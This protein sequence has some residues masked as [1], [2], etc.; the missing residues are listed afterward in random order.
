MWGH[1]SPYL[2]IQWPDHVF[3]I[4]D[5]AT[6]ALWTD[7]I[8]T[9]FNETEASS[10][11]VFDPPSSP[12][13]DGSK[14]G[15]DT[16]TSLQRSWTTVDHLN[17][18]N[19]GFSNLWRTGYASNNTH[20]SPRT[21][22]GLQLDVQPADTSD[23][24]TW[25]SALLTRRRDIQ[26][27]SLRTSM[28]APR[29]YEGGTVLQLGI[30]Y[31]SSEYI[32]SALYSASQDPRL[33]T[34]QWSYSAR[35]A[36][37]DPY[38]QNLTAALGDAPWSSFT[39]HRI[40]WLGSDRLIFSNG[41]LPSDGAVNQ[42]GFDKETDK[43]NLPTLG[44]PVSLSHFSSGDVSMQQ[45]PPVLHQPEARVLY[46]RL[47]FNS[48]SL[49][50]AEAFE[51][52]CAASSGASICSTEDE[53]LRESTPF[54]EEA[55]SPFSARS[56]PR[57]APLYSVIACS[58]AGGLFVLLLVH[59]LSVRY[60]KAN[61]TKKALQEMDASEDKSQEVVA[62]VPFEP[63]ARPSTN[64]SRWEDPD[65]VARAIRHCDDDIDEEDEEAETIVDHMEQDDP[66][67]INKTASG[68][69]DLLGH[70]S[71]ND[72]DKLGYV[73]PQY[74]LAYEAHA[75]RGSDAHSL[76]PSSS[77]MSF[78]LSKSPA[79]GSSA[80]FV[81]SERTPSEGGHWQTSS[82]DHHH[83]RW[84]TPIVEWQAA[85]STDQIPAAGPMAQR[86]DRAQQIDDPTHAAPHRASHLKRFSALAKTTLLGSGSA[87][88]TA[89]G[90]ARVEYL[91]GLR[92]FACFL[93]SLHH[94]LLIFYY[95]ITTVN[96]PMHYAGMETWLRKI[97]GA[98]LV[99][100]GLNVGI[101]FFLAARV[102]A[103]RYLVRGRLQD[104][105]EAIHRRVPRLMLPISAAI[106]INYFLIEAD[107]FHWVLRLA[108][109]TWSPWSY[110]QNYENLGVFINDYLALWFT[111][112]PNVPPLVSLYATGILWTVPVIVQSSWTVFLCALVAREIP[113]PK[114]RYTFYGAC[115]VLS[116][117]ANRFDYFFIAGLIMA[118][119]DNRVKYRQK[120][121]HGFP[122]APASIRERLAPRIANIRVHGQ[123]AAWVVFLTGAVFSWLEF[124]GGSGSDVIKQ[125]HGIHPDWPSSK[126]NA[127][128][129]ST[130]SVDYTDPRFFDF[131]FV[132]GFFLLC[133]L[134][135]SFRTFFQLRFWSAFGRNAFSLYLLHGV[136][137]WS[138]GAW[139]CLALLKH[140]VPY[141]AAVLVVFLTSYM[142]LALL[143]EMFTRTFD[144][145][146]VSISK[147]FWRVTSGG[148]GRR[149]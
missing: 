74:R 12:S 28:V 77:R 2:S 5:P 96:Q 89:S 114:K 121:A 119:L 33:S 30:Q 113:N 1:F 18:W 110:Y 79:E 144:A 49:A 76:A 51:A 93:V 32:R 23:R 15:G 94:F 37:A 145:W 45:S 8:I 3:P 72:E 99:N 115:W 55:L 118:D 97:L 54:T 16:G 69:S 80:S 95:G 60:I 25:G 117:Y 104:L 90:A 125:E 91:D 88:K 132:L 124:V 133:D 47:F 107:A 71:F 112:P 103:N 17:D 66:L 20:L 146:G 62:E 63:S 137:F 147:S 6:N 127:W 46:A 82:S 13:L 92:G 73:A 7:S 48:S 134:C 68:P 105:A 39:E 98:I 11:I 65:F 57:R 35:N 135:N 148:L 26:Y 106:V 128:D 111:I 27:G 4:A 122:L 84:E 140:D 10:G 24:I 52:E 43:T 31:N 129:P 108:S 9:Y 130:R 131:L 141:W 142:W 38:I 87:G 86:T 136:I 149:L 116:W 58:A 75:H 67:R 21:S 70:A 109:R 100:G 139:L 22:E 143:C 29:P 120:A 40:D 53:T 123:A 126:P 14:S 34:L 56:V 41:A 42:L 138:W 102:I 44:G 85:P 61:A 81:I 83:A 36:D 78:D 101:F 64:V 50:R 59:A 19:E